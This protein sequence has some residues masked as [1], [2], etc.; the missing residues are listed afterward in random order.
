MEG[1]NERQR[2][3]TCSVALKGELG[4]GRYRQGV[5]MAEDYKTCHCRARCDE[6]AVLAVTHTAMPFYS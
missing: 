2:E 6:R 1:R 3:T 4:G 5:F